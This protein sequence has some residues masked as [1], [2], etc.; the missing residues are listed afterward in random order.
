MNTTGL[1]VAK[2]IIAVIVLVVILFTVRGYLTDYREAPREDTT[3]PTQ[4]VS[5]SDTQTEP[6]D[7]ADT[8]EPTDADTDPQR[9]T[10]TIDGLNLRT[11]P[12]STAEAVRGL[13]KGEVVTVISKTGDWY[14]VSTEKDEEGFIT[15]NPG[16]TKA[17][18]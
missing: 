10:V 15:D 1:K 5:P 7:D 8:D 14:E 4:T 16:Y 11:K 6:Q 2:G 13:K 17:A 12:D 18:K 3:E 9:L